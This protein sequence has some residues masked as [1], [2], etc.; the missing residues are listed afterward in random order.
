MEVAG[1]ILMGGRNS[2]MDGKKK[3]YL[4]YRNR[5]F[6]QLAAE[7][8]GDIPVYLSVSRQEQ[9]TEERLLY[10]VVEDCYTG[11]GPVGGIASGLQSLPV[12]ALLVAPCDLPLLDK[13]LI[14]LLLDSWRRTGLPAAES[15]GWI[16]PL[17]AI[18]TKDCLPVL[19]QQIRDGNYR[20]SHCMRQ[21][22]HTTIDVSQRGIAPECLQNI[23]NWSDYNQLIN[24]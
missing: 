15:E 6:Y 21:L 3:A 7:A 10:P 23:N 2:R 16:N 18:Y 9:Q 8:M 1:L 4:T 14:E 19:Q 20:A 13:R 11:I 22:P 24:H 17:V 12:R 5:Y